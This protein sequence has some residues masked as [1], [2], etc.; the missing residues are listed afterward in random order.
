M[1]GCVGGWVWV[2]MIL[3]II[4]GCFFVYMDMKEKEIICFSG[5]CDLWESKGIFRLVNMKIWKHLLRGEN[6]YECEIGIDGGFVK[7]HP[8]QESNLGQNPR[9]VL[10]YRCTIGVNQYPYSTPL[11]LIP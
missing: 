3:I 10:C 6:S 9:K 8:N 4:F 1:G 2:G 11:F 7:N 5:D